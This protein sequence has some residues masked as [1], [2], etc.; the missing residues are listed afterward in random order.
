[1]KNRLIHILCILCVIAAIPA[2]ALA[3]TPSPFL[4]LKSK[5]VRLDNIEEIAAREYADVVSCELIKNKTEY[6]LSHLSDEDIRSAKLLGFPFF[7]ETDDFDHFYF[8]KVR[9]SKGLKPFNSVNK[10]ARSFLHKDNK[11]IFVAITQDNDP[12][13]Y[14]Q[15]RDD[16]E[17]ITQRTMSVHG[18]FHANALY[19]AYQKLTLN[20][21]S[22]KFIL[23]SRWEVFLTD[24][25]NM[26][27]ILAEP[28]FDYPLVTYNEFLHAA[29]TMMT[30]AFLSNDNSIIGLQK[31]LFGK[32]V[33]PA[34]HRPNFF[35]HGLA[36]GL[37]L[38]A[39]AVLLGIASF[40]ELKKRKRGASLCP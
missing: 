22:E 19:T 37:V 16:L 24:D 30:E 17:G 3:A 1:M 8:E 33:P 2:L 36:L 18:A 29:N 26:L 38:G 40:A 9:L 28:Y 20:S 31:Y 34:V 15:I 10:F 4:R 27:A 11:W 12:V 35:I 6:S 23:S 7:E 21:T 25:S 14:F 32:N 39:S 13:C 5:A